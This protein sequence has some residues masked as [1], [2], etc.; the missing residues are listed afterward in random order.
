MPSIK[1]GRENT[2]EPD[3]SWQPFDVK[4]CWR[5]AMPGILP[6]RTNVDA[7]QSVTFIYM[8]K[9]FKKIT[10]FFVSVSSAFIPEYG[11]IYTSYIY[12]FT[13]RKALDICIFWL[14]CWNSVQ[15]FRS[16]FFTKADC[17]YVSSL[18]RKRIWPNKKKSYFLFY[19]IQFF[20]IDN[21]ISHH[22]EH[23]YIT[24]V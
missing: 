24:N 5:H 6:A 22:F 11:H 2:S 10:F 17:Y 8:R 23:M 4:T 19:I 1:Y 12:N 9:S 18:N 15:Y 21:V 16:D 3:S 20:F 13:T 14:R 7:T